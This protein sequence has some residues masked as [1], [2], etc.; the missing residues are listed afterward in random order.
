MKSAGY[1]CPILMKIEFSR[2]FCRKI[3]NMKFKENPSSGRQVVP[4]GRTDR[5]DDAKS[6][7]SKFYERA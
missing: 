6:R 2:Q 1:S 3:L 5:H 7:V 4:C